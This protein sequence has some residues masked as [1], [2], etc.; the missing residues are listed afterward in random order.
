MIYTLEFC[1]SLEYS[2]FAESVALGKDNNISHVTL[3]AGGSGIIAAQVLAQLEVPVTALGFAAGYSGGEI[4]SILRKQRI[5][6]DFVYLEDGLSPVNLAVNYGDVY[7]ESTR[8]VSSAPRVSFEDLTALLDKISRLADGDTLLISG[9]V[10]ESIPSDIYEHIPDLVGGRNVRVVLDIPA[11]NAVKC[12]KYAPFLVV[13]DPKRIGDAL[14]EL[15]QSEEEIYS[16]VEQFREMGARNVLASLY[17]GRGAVLLDENGVQHVCE[18]E[19]IPGTAARGIAQ[20]ALIAGYLAG[21]DDSDVDGDYS[22]ML[23]AAASRAACDVNGIPSKP[24]ILE[25]MKTLLKKFAEQ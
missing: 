2:G 11:E 8:F 17:G 14:G 18:A 5:G 10:P 6:T 1:P 16:C 19:R 20:N 23:A 22:L 12:L 24:K 9:E 7:V 21:A 3:R 4:E 25:I 13:L 15:P